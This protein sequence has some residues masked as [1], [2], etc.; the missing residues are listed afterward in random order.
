M[1]C[2]C[3]GLASCTD[4]LPYQRT[5]LSPEKRAK[6]LVSR[7]TLE[8]KV[9]LMQNTSPAI[10]EYGIKAY[11][12]WN[13]ALHGVGRAG[14]ATVF[15]QSVGMAASFNDELLFDVY[16]REVRNVLFFLC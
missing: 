7:L 3:L 8:Q 1:G 10:P 9:S 5:G 15:P 12:W 4:T 11:D 14:L 13:E 6:D 2:V 16:L